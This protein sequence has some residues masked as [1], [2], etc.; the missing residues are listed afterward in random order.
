VLCCDC[1]LKKLRQVAEIILRA[2]ID[3]IRFCLSKN[4]CSKNAR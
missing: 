2:K 4:M 1:F 3:K